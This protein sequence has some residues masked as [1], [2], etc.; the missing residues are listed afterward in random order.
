MA[1]PPAE[2]SGLVGGIR[3]GTR[4]VT[5]LFVVRRLPGFSLSTLLLHHA[6]VAARKM[7]VPEILSLIEPKRVPS[8]KAHSRLG[9]QQRGIL[10]E[11]CRLFRSRSMFYPLGKP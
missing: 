3:R 7:G 2:L 4:V 9:F 11:G 6:L 10:V 1:L 5:H 8:I